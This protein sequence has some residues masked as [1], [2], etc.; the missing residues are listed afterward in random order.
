MSKADGQ[1]IAIKFTL[2]ITSDVST[3]DVSAFTVTGQ[4]YNYVP[5]GELVAGDYEI[6]SV[7]A[8]NSAS[9]DIDL[10]SGTFTDTEYSDGVLKLAEA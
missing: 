4:E 3:L 8:Y 2:P 10:S 1:L 5:G 9:S 6:D 7:E